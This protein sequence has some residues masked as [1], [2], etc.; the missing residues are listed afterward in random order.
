[1]ETSESADEGEVTG[2][3]EALK[4]KV[5][6]TALRWVICLL[7]DAEVRLDGYGRGHDGCNLACELYQA[8]VV[9]ADMKSRV[10]EPGG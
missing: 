5:G 3:H 10:H 9:Q 2:N 4:G 6:E 7:Y 8:R 1:M